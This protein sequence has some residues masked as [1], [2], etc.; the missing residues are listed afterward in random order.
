[1]GGFLL[2]KS[3]TSCVGRSTVR[4]KR[5][6]REIHERFVHGNASEANK[7]FLPLSH[8]T[9]RARR[10]ISSSSE[11]TMIG[12]VGRFP[13]QALLW[14]ETVNLRLDG[15]DGIRGTRRTIFL[16]TIET[17]TIQSRLW[18]DFLPF[19]SM[20]VLHPKTRRMD[21]PRTPSGRM[22]E[23]HESP[24]SER[25]GVRPGRSST[26]RDEFILVRPRERFPPRQLF[27]LLP[28]C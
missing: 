2:G 27:P 24:C 6:V 17:N 8:G 20:W 7:V 5:R 3:R 10:S 11:G 22:R 14:S 26:K 1:M 23:L 12:A 16:T 15:M 19:P 25:S 21:H 9:K 18:E 4:R 13:S 28:S